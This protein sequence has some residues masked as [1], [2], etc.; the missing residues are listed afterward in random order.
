LISSTNRDL[1][2]ATSEE[3]FRLDLYYRIRAVQIELPPLRERPEDIPPLINWFTRQF[4]KRN[5][6]EAPEWSPSALHWLSEQRWDGNVR[7]LH[8]FIEGLLSL[9]RQPGTITLERVQPI[10]AQLVPSSKRLPVLLTRNEFSQFEPYE[11]GIHSEGVG[12]ELQEMRRE[13]RELKGMVATALLRQEEF[14]TGQTSAS[15][16][17]IP[18]F[19]TVRE[20]EIDAVRE[21]LRTANGNRREA[22]QKL[23]ISERTLYRKLRDID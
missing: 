12:R 2:H 8:W 20:R 1:A 6:I 7:E 4:V 19:P 14:R 18:L 11:Q 23:G 10:Y 16:K 13:I 5:R 3:K 17:A 9:D 21:A 22:A 15:D